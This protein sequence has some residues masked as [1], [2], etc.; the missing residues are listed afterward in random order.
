L[1]LVDKSDDYMIF[2][3]EGRLMQVM[4]NLL[5]NGAK[6]ATKGT[7]VSIFI[8]HDNKNVTISITNK[9]PGIPEDFHD[10]VFDRFAQADSSDTRKVGGTGLGLNISKA[11]VETHKGTID[12]T[13]DPEEGTCFFFKLPILEPPTLITAEEL[14]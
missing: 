1:T 9:G 5:S 6:F 12:F 3:D 7:E 10:K 11:I 14:G 13:C 8:Y 2:G 4:A